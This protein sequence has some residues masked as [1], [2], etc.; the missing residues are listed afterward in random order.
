MYTMAL[1]DRLGLNPE[2]FTRTGA[3][4][5]ALRRRGVS[6][7]VA[8]EAERFLRELDESAFS[9]TGKLPEDAASRAASL[10]KTVDE[11]ALPRTS[12]SV[13]AIC[14]VG[15]LSIGI[16]TAHAYDAA[17]A[18]TA[19]DAGVA[20][21]AKHDFVAAREAFIT[22]VVADPNAP[23]AWANLGTASWAGADTARSVAAWQRALRLEPLAADVRDRVELAHSLPWD[24]AGYVFPIPAPWVFEVAAALW[25][26]CW[27]VAA[28][29]AYQER[30]VQRAETAILASIAVAIVISGF[31]LSERLAGRHLAVVR[32]TASLS[33]DP[34]LGGERG[35]TAIIGEVVR[36][37]GRQGAWTRVILDDGRDG[38]LETS[39]LLSLDSR[40]VNQIGIQ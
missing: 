7:D 12:I 24:S 3:L 2:S 34:Q 30:P 6:T 22:S 19:F 1:G 8:L 23:D 21:Y 31:V 29:R 28:W 15:L 38:W 13:P 25:I 36:V 39:T 14:I 11:E 18:R 32:H 4:A 9:A 20:A 35:P 26:L 40:D 10:Y 17:T 37:G 16:A 5:R 33:T 27:G